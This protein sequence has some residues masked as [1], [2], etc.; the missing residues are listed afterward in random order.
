MNSRILPAVALLIAVGIF[1]VY[2]NPTWTGSIRT[3]RATIKNSDQAI[4]AAEQYTARQNQLAAERDAIDPAQLAALSTFLPDS[5]DNVQLIIDLNA[6][7]AR[8]GLSVADI[9]VV[10]DAF[11]ESSAESD[12]GAIG[13][14][15]SPV[16][17][18]DLSLSASGTFAALQTFLKGIEKSARLLDVQDL[19][20]QGSETGIYNYQMTMHLYWLR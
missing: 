12:T 11:G 15:S 2:V 9:D 8:S 16:N 4:A 13:T 18:V 1:F 17:S 19:V 20:V 3:A 10:A 5:V 7:A 6:L 14:D